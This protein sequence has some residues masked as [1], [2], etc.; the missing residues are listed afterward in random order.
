MRHP[1]KTSGALWEGGGRKAD[2]YP[3]L[4]T[5]LP[6]CRSPFFPAFDQP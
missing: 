6:G 5:T 1:E 4:R 3:D 2:P